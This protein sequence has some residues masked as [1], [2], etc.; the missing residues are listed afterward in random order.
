MQ[1]ALSLRVGRSWTEKHWVGAS[2]VTTSG[3][4]Y[5]QALHGENIVL[6]SSRVF[7]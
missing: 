1:D 2:G 6:Q 5:C 4:Q 3:V 7:T